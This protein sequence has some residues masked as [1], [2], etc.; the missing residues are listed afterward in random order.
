MKGQSSG[1]RISAK[2]GDG[3]DSDFSLKSRRLSYPSHGL[4]LG[5]IFFSSS[6]FFAFF[7]GVVKGNVREARE[8]KNARSVARRSKECAGHSII[9]WINTRE[10]CHLKVINDCL[11]LVDA[12]KIL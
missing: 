12:S 6:F 1:G 4:P 3:G 2:R 11:A 7:G 8:N 10:I 5:G 9:W